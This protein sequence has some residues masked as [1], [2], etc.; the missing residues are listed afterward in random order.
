MAE[1]VDKESKTEDP[2]PRRREEARRQG[3]VPFSSELVGSAVLLAGVMGLIYIGPSIWETMIGIFRHDLT[4]LF[5]A[6]F[7]L[8]G[9]REL[10]QRTSILALTALT[11]LFG[12]LLAVGVGASILQVGFQINA[13]KMELNFD[14]LNP[15]NGFGRLFSIASLVR[16]LLTLLKI[17]A[18]AFVAF[19]VIEGRGVVLTSLS[20]NRLPGATASGWAIVLRLAT[21]L[22]AAV[23]LVAVIDYIYQRRRFEQS[24]KMTKQELKEELKREEGDPQ[25]KG[26][27]RQLQRDRARRR[28]LAEVPKA[29]VVVTNPSHYA[30]ALRY[31]APRDTAPVVVA[32]AHGPFA[33]RIAELARRHSIPVLERPPL[34]RALYAGVREGQAI[35]GPLF[36]AVAEVLAFVYRVRGFGPDRTPIKVTKGVP[37]DA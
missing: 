14:K 22:S 11:P 31:E 18:L 2:T 21:Y 16:G 5:H 30:V 19:W 27:I 15:A 10:L 12:L 29:T 1:E 26:R 24:I 17:I 8:E 35:P 4:R 36:R 3:Q 6:E 37:G 23:T 25:I 13:E 33:R 34:A 20:T 9:A 28:M 32:K 7:G